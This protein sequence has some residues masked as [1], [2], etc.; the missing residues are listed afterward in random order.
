VK[1]RIVL[2]LHVLFRE[3]DAAMRE[4]PTV[5]VNR[6]FLS[7]RGARGRGSQNG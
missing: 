5:Q 4:L 3:K 2:H 1:R 6:S 7:D